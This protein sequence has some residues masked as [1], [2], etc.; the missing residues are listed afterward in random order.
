MMKGSIR[1]DSELQTLSVLKAKDRRLD[2]FHFWH[3]ELMELKKG[4]TASVDF[5]DSV[6]V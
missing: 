1:L 2:K 5:H 6:V 3:D 4:R